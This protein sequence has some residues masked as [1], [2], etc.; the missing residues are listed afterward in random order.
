[1]DTDNKE[2]SKP[3]FLVHGMKVE[4]P[5]PNLI[6]VHLR[7]SVVPI[8]YTSSKQALGENLYLG[9]G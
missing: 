2:F 3:R 4:F 1:M 5:K 8:P 9:E 7:S 6:R